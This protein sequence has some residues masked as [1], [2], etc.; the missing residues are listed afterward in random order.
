MIIFG[1]IF[2]FILL[3]PEVTFAQIESGSFDFD[4][5]NRSYKICL[6]DNYSETANL[7]LVFNLHPLL[8]DAQWHMGYSRMHVVADTFGYIIVYPYAVL[9]WNTGRLNS[10][11]ELVF[12]E[13]DVG[14]INA[15]IDTLDNHY[16]IDLERIYACG[17][18]NGAF[19]SYRLACELGHRIAAIASV[20]GGMIISNIA[21]CNPTRNIPVLH[22]HGT[23]DLSVPIGGDANRYSAD[24]TIDYW[25]DYNNCVEKTTT[26]LED[27][28]PEDGCTVEKISY[29]SC[30]YNCNVL[31]LKVHGGGHTWPGG[32]LQKYNEGNTNM[33]INAGYE[34]MKF[35]NEAQLT[36]A[37]IESHK[38]DGLFNVYPNP[39]DS[40]TIISFQLPTDSNVEIR[41]YNVSGQ[42][43]KTY[44]FQ[45]KTAGT[46]EVAWDGTNNYGEYVSGGLYLISLS[47]LDF[48]K[49][50]KALYL[51]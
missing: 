3:I 11:G 29:T 30:D 7:P 46:H 20:G 49:T 16:S 38:F 12:D 13:D 15:L 31:Y 39:F 4:G 33:D 2:A 32:N 27:L 19:M 47:R 25:I 37:S 43:I 1:G 28:D 41:I 35:F 26:Y 48:H 8:Y 40:E 14:F 51:R 17:F 9:E 18:S 23:D 10:S 34:I 36:P 24:Q 22:I 6:P 42:E 5:N 50:K 45:N 21:N 44:R